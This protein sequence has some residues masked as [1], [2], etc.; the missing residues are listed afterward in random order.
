MAAQ[1]AFIPAC[2]PWRKKETDKGAVKSVLRF[3][4]E[5]GIEP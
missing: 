2:G 1:E 4:T 3:L 5:A